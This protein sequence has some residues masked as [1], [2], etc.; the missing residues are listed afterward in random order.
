MLSC[1]TWRMCC[2]RRAGTVAGRARLR[3]KDGSYRLLEGTWSNL[4]H[5]RGVEALAVNFR[6]ITEQDR[7]RQAL[8]DSEARFRSLTELA[9]DWFWEQDEELRFTSFAGGQGDAKW[10]GDQSQAIGLRRWEIPGITPLSASWEEHRAL[11][12][13]RRPFRD[14]EYMRVTESGERRYVTSSGE[15]IHDADGTFTGYRG[16]AAD[17]TERKSAETA[18]PPRAHGRAPP[19]RCGDRGRRPGCR[20]ARDLRVRRLGLRALFR[21]RRGRGAIARHQ[22]LGIG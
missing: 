15:P 18:H 16:T 8:A 9:S 4:L 12:Q 1:A 14:F 11:L 10:G 22:V 17:I 7:S 13:A 5:L 6:D 19:G 3:H 2:A 21:R 20:D